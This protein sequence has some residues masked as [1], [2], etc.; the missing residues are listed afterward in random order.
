[1]MRARRLQADFG[2]RLAEQFAILGLVDRGRRRADHLDV[3]LFEHAHFL[4]RQ[5]AI[6]RGLAAHRRQQREAAGNGVTLLGD[7]LGDDLRGDRLDIGAVRHIRIGHDRGGIGIDQDD[8]IALGAQGLAGLGAGIIEF[9]RLADDD[10]AGA[11]DEDRRNVCP[12]RHGSPRLPLLRRTRSSGVLLGAQKKA[13]PQASGA[14]KRPDMKP[15]A[16]PT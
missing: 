3:I 1:M 5:S 12:L 2:H 8:A 7:D 9:A 11:D 16:A 13:A 6:Q 14:A 15:S 4:Q 10:R